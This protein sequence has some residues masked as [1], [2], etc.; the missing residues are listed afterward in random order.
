MKLSRPAYY[1]RK[2][3]KQLNVSLAGL[4]LRKKT[5]LLLAK[6]WVV[7][8]IIESE[9]RAAVMTENKRFFTEVATLQT[10]YFRF[11]IVITDQFTKQLSVSLHSKTIARISANGSIEVKSNYGFNRSFDTLEA[12]VEYAIDAYI[13]SQQTV[14]PVVETSTMTGTHNQIRLLLGAHYLTVLEAETI[15]ITEKITQAVIGKIIHKAETSSFYYQMV[16]GGRLTP[17]KYTQSVQT[18]IIS[19]KRTHEQEMKLA[20]GF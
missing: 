9:V 1:I 16:I 4:D 18:A 17:E 2:I 20:I 5:D 3:A 19:I 11:S 6:A 14:K 10:K 15:T 12:A 13:E 8:A 7:D